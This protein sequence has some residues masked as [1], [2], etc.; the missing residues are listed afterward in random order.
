[1]RKPCLAITLG[2]IATAGAYGAPGDINASFD[3]PCKYPAG[4]ATDGTD[5]FVLD[6]RDAKIHQVSPADGKVKKTLPA[7][8]LK[9]YGLAYGDG[10]LFVSDDHTGRVYAMDVQSGIVANLFDAPGTQPTGLAYGDKSLFILE[11]KSGQIYKVMPD[12]GTILAYLPTPN[13]TCTCLTYDGKYLWASDRVRNEIYL[14]E[15]EHGMVVGILAAPGPYTA[16]LARIGDYLWNVDFQTRTLYQLVLHDEQRYRLSEPREARVEYVWA[17]YNYG[18]GEV[19]D[20]VASFAMPQPLRNQELLSEFEFASP[21]TKTV[22]DRWGQ[23]CAV[24]EVPTL[25]PGQRQILS[26]NVKAR[27]SAIRYLIFP[28]EVGPLRDI[29]DDIRKTYTAD[30]SRYRLSTPFIQE[31]VRTIVGDE[32]N[33]YWVAR[34]IY[35]YVVDKITYEMVGGWDVPEVVLKRGKGSCSEFTFTF[36]ALCRAA[37]LPARYQGSIVVRG[38]DASVDDAFHRWAEIYLPNYGWIPVDA[39]RGAKS[40]ADQAR[41]I[42]ELSNRFLITTHGGGDSEYLWWGYNAY[43]KYKTTGYA[44]VEEDNYGL[45]EPLSPADKPAAAGE[46]KRPGGCVMP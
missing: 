33:A 2:F 1:M 10:K 11:R 25:A 20:I 41:G 13:D 16:G 23:A 9:G 29:P 39:S 5:L 30:G 24:Y 14:I 36:I 15:P 32:Q 17:L 4:L 7:P 34:K 43:A 38:D 22:P 8:A 3:A 37:G 26:Y 27:I 31:T 21:P 40:P 44:K 45:W 19:K 42:G 6:W 46:T 18:P 35:N 12:D 28:D